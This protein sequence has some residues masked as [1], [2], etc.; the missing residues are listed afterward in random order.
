MVFSQWAIKIKFNK[1]KKEYI[2]D[3][4]KTF[5]SEIESAMEVL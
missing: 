5:Y 2:F 1:L 4:F 3:Y